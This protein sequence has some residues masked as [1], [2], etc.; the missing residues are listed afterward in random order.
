MRV[1]IVGGGVI[2]LATAWR[3][4]QR[5][6]DVTVI[7]PEP[8]TKASGVAA[9]LLP[10]SGDMLLG[11]PEFARL[12][13]HSRA[14]YPSFAAELARAAGTPVGYLRNGIL[15]VAYDARAAEGLDRLRK[16]ADDAGV[17]YEM[18]TPDDCRRLEPH[19]AG[20]AHVGMLSPD[21]GSVDP[22]SL[23]RALTAALRHAGGRLVRERATELLLDTGT[24]AVRLGDGTVQHA[25]RLVLAA[26]PWTHLLPGLP[27][28]L[29]PE[30]KPYKGQVIRLRGDT[31]V[32][33]TVR[34]GYEDRAVYIAP[35]AD[36]ELAVGAT[37]E[38][39]GYDEQVRAEGVADLLERVRR[40]LPAASRMHF[41]GAAA[42]LRPGSPDGQPILGPTSREDVLLATGHHRVGVQLTPATAEAMA[43]AVVTGR[44]PD[45]ARPFGADRFADTAP[46][47]V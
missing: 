8:G 35:R 6:T 28:G 24:P 27:E 42:A 14:L 3:C 37:Y 46:T 47:P 31:P 44:L 45:I 26:G 10:P 20:E 41:A 32:H 18:L 33:H 36:G 23:T 30:I 34:C 4:A 29:V 39:A 43:E 40:V 11:R 7:D 19:L 38:D 13:L 9:G 16:M 5:G 17:R 12:V 22:R 25:D 2:G 21:D 1:I 15:D